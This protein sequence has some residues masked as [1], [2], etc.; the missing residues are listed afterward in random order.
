MKK[1]RENPRNYTKRTNAIMQMYIATK[2]II[3]PNQNT[4][5]V[6]RQFQLSTVDTQLLKTRSN[7]IAFP[8]M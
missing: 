7:I 6:I 5:H 8:S 3:I 4:S 1:R 2:V